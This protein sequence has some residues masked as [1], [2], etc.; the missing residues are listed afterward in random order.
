[1]KEKPSL[2]WHRSLGV[3]IGCF[4]LIAALSGSAIAFYHSLDASLNPWQVSTPPHKEAQVSDPLTHIAQIEGRVEG[5][6]VTWV[7]LSLN[8]QSSWH[9]F[10]FPKNM[11]K[12]IANNEVYVDPY[13]GAI[14]GMRTWGDI[15]QGWT[16]L[17]PFIYKLHYALALGSIGVLVMGLVALA[18]FVVLLCGVWITFPKWDKSFLSRWRKSW[19]WRFKGDLRSKS[20]LLHKT[21]GL[22]FLPFLLLMAWS[23]FALN[24]HELHERL[25]SSVMHFQTEH[26]QIKDLKRP[27]P[28]P[29]LSWVEARDIGRGLMSELSFKEGFEI[30]EESSIMYNGL[31]GVYSYSVKSS[32]DIE[33]D[34]GATTVY[35]DG[36]SGALKASFIPTGKANGTT[37]VQWLEGLH[38]GS[39]WGLPH[40][41]VLSFL[42]GVITLFVLSG[43]FL[44]WKRRVNAQKIGTKKL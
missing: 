40:R 12:P 1:M 2:K 8:H 16:N 15:T 7:S 23:S 3:A 21:A 29:K 36:N 13:N 27:R 20:Y 35:F 42:G 10:L 44:W 28:N 41:V 19:K 24:L 18:W 9:Y 14:K 17:L 22:W 25:L 39:I 33:I 5:A 37:L 26:D 6:K 11:A 30:L 4:I 38:K 34:H 31:K 43:F 32:R